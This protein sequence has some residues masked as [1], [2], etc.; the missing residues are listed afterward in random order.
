MF[1]LL[2]Q[3]FDSSFVFSSG[4]ETY[5]YNRF[6]RLRPLDDPLVVSSV[7]KVLERI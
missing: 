7:E 4:A 3:P 5:P 6:V 1:N 2:T